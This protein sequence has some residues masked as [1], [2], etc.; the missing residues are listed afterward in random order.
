MLLWN[1]FYF[2]FHSN[3]Q[4]IFFSKK[5]KK[6]DFSV[7]LFGWSGLSCSTWDLHCGKQKPS[8][9]QWALEGMGS[10]VAAWPSLLHSMWDLSLTR[11]RIHFPCIGRRILQH[12]TTREVPEKVILTEW[13]YAFPETVLIANILF[14][15][16][17]N[18]PESCSLNFWFKNMVGEIL[19]N[20][21]VLK[22]E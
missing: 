5:K 1:Y 14:D 6:D 15:R 10:G 13:P 22:E 17:I 19:V 4:V 12:W 20:L 7:T 2:L 8:S 18:A 9:Q 11:D 3:E 16:P 21:H